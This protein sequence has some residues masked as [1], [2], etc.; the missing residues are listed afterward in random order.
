[1]AMGDPTK[2]STLCREMR[3]AFATKLAAILHPGM[4]G[5]RQEAA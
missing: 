1:M 2:T 5:D 3:D 4:T